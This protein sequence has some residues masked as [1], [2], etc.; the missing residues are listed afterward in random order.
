LPR[1]FGFAAK[2]RKSV[3]WTVNYYLGQEHPDRIEAATPTSPIPVQPGLNVV[4]IT[5]APNGRTHIFDSYLTW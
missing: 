2:P 4:A 5:P 1:L 3:S